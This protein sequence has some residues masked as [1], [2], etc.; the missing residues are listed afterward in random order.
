MDLIMMF[1]L[2]FLDS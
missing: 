2:L 1:K